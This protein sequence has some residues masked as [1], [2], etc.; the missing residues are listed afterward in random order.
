MIL[1]L[2]IAQSVAAT[3]AMGAAIVSY[4][5]ARRARAAAQRRAERER[6]REGLA[7]MRAG[8]GRP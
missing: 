4:R 6:M 2:M 5:Y 1:A 8:D 3:G 7:R